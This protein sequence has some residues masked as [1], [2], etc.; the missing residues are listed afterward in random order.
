MKKVFNIEHSIR[1]IFYLLVA[2]VVVFVLY[3]VFLYW[4]FTEIGNIMKGV[5]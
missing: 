3:F 5:N 1:D 2:L 4:S